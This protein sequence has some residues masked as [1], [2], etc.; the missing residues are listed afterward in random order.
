MHRGSRW[1]AKRL[2]VSSIFFSPPPHQEPITPQ[3]IGKML[4]LRPRR[5]QLKAEWK[6]PLHEPKEQGKNWTIVLPFWETFGN[7]FNTMCEDVPGSG[8]QS[9]SGRPYAFLDDANDNPETLDRIR[10]WIDLVGG[11]VAIRDCLALSF[12]LDYDREQGDPKRPQTRIGALRTRAKPYGAEPT[13]DT[14]KAANKLAKECRAFLEQMTCYASFDA[15]VAMPPS[16]PDK[17]FDLPSHIAARLAV[18][19]GRD[20]LTAAV[21]TLRARRQL[22]NVAVAEKLATLQGS[23]AVDAKAVKSRVVLLVDDLYQSGVSM[24]Y[25]AMELL[26]SGARKVFGL[27]C[28]KTCRNDDNVGGSR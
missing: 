7:A 5:M 3:A 16:S 2:K 15:V 21:T 1:F 14:I 12:A 28:E 6:N 20:D 11:F 25:V 19:L 18:D 10:A 8:L 23:I 27:A 26:Q 4:E 13:D 22:K 9:G 17:A 24:N